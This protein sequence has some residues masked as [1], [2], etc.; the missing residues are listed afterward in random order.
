EKQTSASGASSTSAPVSPGPY[1]LDFLH[2]VGV[3]MTAGAVN[4]QLS[5]PQ[6]H[7]HHLQVLAQANS[8]GNR[9]YNSPSISPLRHHH[10]SYLSLRHHRPYFNQDNSQ[11][12]LSDGTILSNNS[13]GGK[14]NNFEIP[15]LY[16]HHP[17]HHFPPHRNSG[18]MNSPI[19]AESFPPF[20]H[21]HHQPASS[22]NYQ[23]FLNPQINQQN[24]HYQQYNGNQGNNGGNLSRSN[25]SHMIQ[26]KKSWNSW[27][28]K[29]HHHH[30][31]HHNN[32][33]KNR[34]NSSDHH[35]NSSCS[36]SS[37]TSSA[38]S[39]NND[40]NSKGNQNVRTLTYVSTDYVN[41]RSPT[42]SPKSISP[43]F[44]GSKRLP[45]N[46]P[47]LPHRLPYISWTH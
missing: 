10:P 47:Q 1:S 34:A 44:Q 45:Q 16:H 33:Q 31:H 25:S 40:S 38:T 5:L 8:S 24:P 29:N 7:P 18:I 11:M 12:V 14:S 30:H 9:A 35:S 13:N 20:H 42:P 3:Q 15:I 39:R 2:Q 19:A 28:S 41:S 6:S 22:H 46:N 27:K 36:S 43:I 17:Q 21:F 23:N 26:Q 32:S 4:Q 37:S